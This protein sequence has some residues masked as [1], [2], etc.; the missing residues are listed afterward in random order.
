VTQYYT[1]AVG[2]KRP[3]RDDRIVAIIGQTKGESVFRWA[4]ND[5]DVSRLATEVGVSPDTILWDRGA[6]VETPT[7]D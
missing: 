7:T 3:G 2:P 6:F 1:I 5:Q 4:V